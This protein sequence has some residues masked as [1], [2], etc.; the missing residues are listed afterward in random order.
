[1]ADVS[2]NKR[3]G[4]SAIPVGVPPIE[5][6]IYEQTFSVRGAMSGVRLLKIMRAL[7]GNQREGDE[8]TTDAVLGFLSDA[9]LV[10]D[11]ER[12]MDFLENSD[13]PVEFPLLMEIVQ[14]L[15]EQY[16]GN[17]T[18]QP[19]QSG[20]TSTSTG[21][22]SSESASSP[23][24]QTSAILTDTSSSPSHPHLSDATH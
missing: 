6:N 16:V 5:L 9:F 19:A 22:S 23:Q 24:V 14:W 15:V 12:G 21:I 11:R 1:M 8:S 3:F 20:D 4:G 13:P 10:A 2:K 17:P 18:G 7:D